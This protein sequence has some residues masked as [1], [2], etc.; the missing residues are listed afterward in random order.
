M[1]QN[2]R[3][4]GVTIVEASFAIPILLMFVMALIDLGMWTLN[5]NQAAN[6]ARD[7]ARTGIIFYRL[8][9]VPGSADYDAIVD[10]IESHLPGH[11]VEVQDIDIRCVNPAG[12]PLVGKCISARP[13][14]DRLEV[15]IDWTWSLI[16][17]IA[18]VIG[19]EEGVASGTASHSIIGR[20]VAGTPP[21]T[22]TTSSTSSTTTTVAGDPTPCTISNI[23][24]LP[25]PVRSKSNG[26]LKS[27]LTVTYTTNQVERCNALAVQLTT[28][29][30]GKKL[31]SAVCNVCELSQNHSWSYSSNKP[32]WDHGP[33]T[34]RIF[35][36]FVDISATFN[37]TG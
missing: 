32:D 37:V 31:V 33:A 15:S 17:P 6:A 14:V 25:A 35:N 13:G 10:K 8:A 24:V 16:T 26:Q 4:D 29:N 5:D 1:R 2:R 7:G 22:T 19:V 3:D 27:D 21:V 18:G 11:E 28:P 12:T 30:P 20:P 36:E 23:Q 9:D 34:V